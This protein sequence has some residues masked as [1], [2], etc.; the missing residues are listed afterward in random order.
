MSPRPTAR[1]AAFAVATLTAAGLFGGLAAPASAA[2]AA[3]A[4][5]TAPA[6]AP[7]TPVT[8]GIHDGAVNTCIAVE[9][10]AKHGK[11]WATRQ[12]IT[13][14]PGARAAA[15]S[16]FTNKN[17]KP[18]NV[19]T[20]RFLAPWDIA[21]HDDGNAAGNHQ[22]AVKEACMDAWLTGA[23]NAG[24]QPE[25]D[26][27]V[28]RNYKRHGKVTA[29]DIHTYRVAVDAFTKKYSDPAS[30]GSRARVLII[31]PWNEPDIPGKAA[32]RIYLP[33]GSRA[34]SDPNCKSGVNT[35]GPVLAGRMWQAVRASCEK[36]GTVIAGNFSSLGGVKGKESGPHGRFAGSFLDV[37][38]SHLGHRPAV[39]ALH[40]YTDVES[41]ENYRAKHKTGYPALSKT[42]V[43]TFASDLN[44]AGYHAGTQIWLNEISAFQGHNQSGDSKPGW[45]PAIQADAARYL[46]NTL[47]KAAAKPKDPTVTRAYYLNFQ[48]N[49]ATNNRWSLI[50]D[51]GK[52]QPVWH[53]LKNR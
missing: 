19:S 6:A 52:V 53:A 29:P 8:L 41:F 34:M 32:K 1:Y 35:C 16:S 15:V 28:D 26:L 21:R 20:V 38:R 23:R 12:N 31:A 42:L 10:K 50:L 39:W 7:K 11:G 51:N 44:R 5:T 24:A 45:T 30:T 25:I 40:P 18:L 3:S 2:T 17:W 13:L 36:C 46:L 4:A 33:Q 48:S 43:A 37:Y 14:A 9:N 22:L 47:P 27:E 49:N